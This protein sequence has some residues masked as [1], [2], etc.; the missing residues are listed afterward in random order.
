M[1][2]RNIIITCPIA[3]FGCYMVHYANH[4]FKSKSTVSQIKNKINHIPTK[5]IL[6]FIDAETDSKFTDCPLI[7]QDEGFDNPVKF[8]QL[9]RRVCRARHS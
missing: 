7:K 2:Y 3:V 5:G 4:V 8:C 9:I 6:Y 1:L